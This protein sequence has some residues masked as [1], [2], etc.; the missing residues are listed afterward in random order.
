MT[1]APSEAEVPTDDDK[2]KSE[3]SA[4]RRMS[5][6]GTE[7]SRNCSRSSSSEESNTI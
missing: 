3:G 6:A 4:G 2:A 7:E 5:T 1:S